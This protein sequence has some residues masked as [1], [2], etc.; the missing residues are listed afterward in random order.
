[1]QRIEPPSS[2]VYGLTNKIGRVIYFFDTK[3]IMIL[4]KRHGAGVQPHVHH[5]FRASHLATAIAFK[6]HFIDIRSVEVKLALFVFR[7]CLVL[8]ISILF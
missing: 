5:F 2:L 4:S 8:A 1:M 3:W 7:K 6:C